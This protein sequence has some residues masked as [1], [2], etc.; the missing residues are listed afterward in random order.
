MQ[1]ELMS[2]ELKNKQLV[3]FM[4]QQQKA[5]K[6]MRESA[7][8]ERQLAMTKQEETRLDK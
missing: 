1:L 4:I 7:A 8:R 2:K 5:S 3:M 6:N